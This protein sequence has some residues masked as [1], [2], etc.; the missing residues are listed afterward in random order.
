ML[1][2]YWPIQF[3]PEEGYFGFCDTYKIKDNAVFYRDTIFNAD[4][5][6]FE[7]IDCHYGKDNETAFKGKERIKYSH[8]ETFK[9][10]DSQWQKDKNSYYYQG[11]AL[12]NI[13]YETFEILDLG[14]SKDKYRVYYKTTVLKGAESETF[15]INRMNGIGTDS[16]NEFKNGKK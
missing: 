2:F 3:N 11:Q 16:Q 1:F 14:Y 8:S 15:K 9:V 7:Y 13:D 12:E 5:L 10:I 4:P 6:T